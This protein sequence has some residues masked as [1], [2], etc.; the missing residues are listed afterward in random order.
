MRLRQYT[1]LSYIER[2]ASFE[3]WPLGD[4][5]D[6]R[7]LA[8]AGFYHHRSDIAYCPE[9]GLMY[10][11]KDW[12]KDEN[13]FEEHAKFSKD[14]LF[15]KFFKSANIVIT[16]EEVVNYWMSTDVV[17]QFIH[18]NLHNIPTIKSGLHQRL[19]MKFKNFENL[20]E[21]YEFFKDKEAI[22]DLPDDKPDDKPAMLCKRHLHQKENQINQEINQLIETFQ[23]LSLS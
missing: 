2:L 3:H 9:C 22:D 10:W 1:L 14:C 21:I 23:T 13:P 6:L 11:K 12:K 8:G 17:R 20:N 4:Y 7:I 18:Q 15:V 19:R 16:D 5:L